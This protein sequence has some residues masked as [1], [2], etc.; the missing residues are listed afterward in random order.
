[1]GSGAHYNVSTVDYNVSTVDDAREWLTSRGQLWNPR[2]NRRPR[3]S[4]FKTTAVGNWA[5]DCQKPPLCVIFGKTTP[6][7]LLNCLFDC[8]GRLKHKCRF[9]CQKPILGD[10]D[11]SRECSVTM[12]QSSLAR[13]W[14]WTWERKWTRPNLPSPSS[15]VSCLCSISSSSLLPTYRPHRPRYGFYI[16]YQNISPLAIMMMMIIKL[17]CWKQFSRFGRET[18]TSSNPSPLDKGWRPTLQSR[19]PKLNKNVRKI[20]VLSQKEIFKNALFELTEIWKIW[21]LKPNERNVKK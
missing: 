15:P 20:S 5:F 11:D 21:V 3:E 12:M 19:W 10:I 14:K 4:S 17:V 6:R 8:S 2:G 9:D 1:M 13:K 7:K 16:L 18:S